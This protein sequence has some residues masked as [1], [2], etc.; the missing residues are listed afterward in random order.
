MELKE[1][2][3]D[4]CCSTVRNFPQRLSEKTLSYFG[5][6]LPNKTMGRK[7]EKFQEYLHCGTLLP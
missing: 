4:R 7:E 1:I 5:N 6:F 2:C 3:V